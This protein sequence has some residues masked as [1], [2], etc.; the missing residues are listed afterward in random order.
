[1]ICVLRKKLRE[2]RAKDGNT[3][4]IIIIIKN[5]EEEY[6]R[7]KGKSKLKSSRVCDVPFNN[8]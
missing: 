3:S 1:M 8:D 5:L 6:H 2:V 4:K 7:E